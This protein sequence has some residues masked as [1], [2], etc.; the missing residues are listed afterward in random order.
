MAEV[1]ERAPDFTLPDQQGNQ[2]ALADFRG[3][4]KVMLVFYVLAW[5]GI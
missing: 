1:G 5:T 2:V 3:Q 4:K